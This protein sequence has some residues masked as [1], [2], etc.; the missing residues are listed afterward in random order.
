MPLAKKSMFATTL[1]GV[2]PTCIIE[3]KRGKLS[4]PHQLSSLLYSIGPVYW[5]ISFSPYIH[6]L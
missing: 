1:I 3:L 4:T 6:V 2:A 5:I